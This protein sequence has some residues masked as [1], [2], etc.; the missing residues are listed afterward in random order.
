M[1]PLMYFLHRKY[2]KKDITEYFGIISFSTCGG[3]L[4]LLNLGNKSHMPFK[5]RGPKT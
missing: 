4:Y 1:M 5:A 3:F 2:Y